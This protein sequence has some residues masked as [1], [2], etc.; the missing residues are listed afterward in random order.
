MSSLH[1]LD[2]SGMVIQTGTHVD[3][4]GS[5]IQ[6]LSRG[7]GSACWVFVLLVQIPAWY[8]ACLI[9]W[10]RASWV[11]GSFS[12]DRF[13]WQKSSLRVSLMENEGLR[14]S[15]SMTVNLSSFWKLS[16]SA[17]WLQQHKWMLSQ[18]S[19]CFCSV[20]IS[21]PSLPQWILPFSVECRCHITARRSMEYW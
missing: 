2:T 10:K 9:C 19:E 21:L 4:P 1:A 5:F 13:S 3:V 17:S 14:L 18:A 20:I 12:I 7:D 15:Y 16:E 8:T 11:G 6:P